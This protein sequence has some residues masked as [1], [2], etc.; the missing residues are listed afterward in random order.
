MLRVV[1]VFHSNSYFQLEY[2]RLKTG[3]L[4][5]LRLNDRALRIIEYYSKLI[6]SDY[7]FPVFDDI[8]LFQARKKNSSI[9]SQ[10]LVETTKHS[11]S[12][13]LWL[14]ITG[15]WSNV[16][17]S[18]VC[19]LFSKD[20]RQKNSKNYKWYLNNFIHQVKTHKSYKRDKSFH[21]ISFYYR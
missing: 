7:L 19:S 15:F 18:A 1:A 5:S 11:Q 21:V 8:L 17:E 6:Y 20:Y 9:F 2:I 4:I 3:D 12:S 14:G 16:M 13:F 10:N